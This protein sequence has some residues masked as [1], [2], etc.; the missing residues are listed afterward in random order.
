MAAET[1]ILSS[2]H[3]AD[4]VVMPHQRCKQRG[5]TSQ[6]RGAFTEV[7]AHAVHAG[8]AAT[9]V[10]FAVP[11]VFLAEFPIKSIWTQAQVFTKA[12]RVFNIG[13]TCATTEA[14]AGLHS[15]LGKAKGDSGEVHLN[16]HSWELYCSSLARERFALQTCYPLL[17]KLISK[18]FP[19]S[20]WM[21]LYSLYLFIWLRA[22][23]Q[24]DSFFH[25]LGAH[26]DFL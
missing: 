18:Q 21:V 19:L 1:R 6:T 17:W 12:W 15:N 4:V 25:H 22:P 26:S 5:V 14:A 10:W 3:L 11:D 20:R 24:R 16:N 23:L 8:S 13:D 9:G 7:A 2:V